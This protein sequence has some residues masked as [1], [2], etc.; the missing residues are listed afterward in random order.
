[1]KVE[2]NMIKVVD[3]EFEVAS[4]GGKRKLV[5]LEDGIETHSSDFSGGKGKI[6]VRE[7]AVVMLQDGA[8]TRRIWWIWAVESSRCA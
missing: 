2:H 5:V 4:G 1:M 6:T 3:I 8:G 7:N